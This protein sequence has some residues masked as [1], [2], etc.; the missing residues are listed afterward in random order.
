MLLT[1]TEDKPKIKLNLTANTE[2]CKISK[3]ACIV[4]NGGGN[5]MQLNF[6]SDTGLLNNK[7]QIFF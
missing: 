1:C 3:S 6:D 7:Q 4:N 5:C 2:S